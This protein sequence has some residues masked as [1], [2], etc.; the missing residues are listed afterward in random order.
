MIRSFCIAAKDLKSEFRT[1]QMLNSMFIF[2]LMVLVVFSISFADFLGDSEKVEK[3]APGVLWVSFT[4]A[5]MLGLSRSFVLESEN[6]CLEALKLCPVDM[7]TIYTGKV[8]SNLGIMF[9]M[10]IVTL[11]F[12]IGLFSYNF[13]LSSLFL[14]VFILLLGTFGFIAVGT[15]LAALTL[16]TRT[17]ELLLPVL[18]LPVLLPVLIPAVEATAEILAGKGIESLISE[19]RLLVAYDLVFF[20][21]SN[22]IFEYVVSD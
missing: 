6:G 18:L 13:G 7:S 1:K 17:R 9:L 12:F 5:G 2:S 15:L 4:F 11:V 16:S 21:V 3:V 8:L 10:E 20:S 22:L 19:I 14:L